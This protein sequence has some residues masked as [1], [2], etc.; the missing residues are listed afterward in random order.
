M[1]IF[2]ILWPKEFS[3]AKKALEEKRPIII[4][5][6]PMECG[7]DFAKSLIELDHARTIDYLKLSKV[8]L[9]NLKDNTIYLSNYNYSYSNDR[10][11]VCEITLGTID[12]RY[13]RKLFNHIMVLNKESVTTHL[14]ESTYQKSSGFASFFIKHMNAYIDKTI[15]QNSTYN[16]LNLAELSFLKLIN[17]F[18]VAVSTDIIT[19][20]I[21]SLNQKF[22][23]YGEDRIWSSSS[24]FE[25]VDLSVVDT[26][27]FISYLEKISSKYIQL[28]D[29]A[30]VLIAVLK[31]DE[32]LLQ[33]YFLKN[34]ELYL[35]NVKLNKY[36]G[37]VSY[38]EVET[39]VLIS[40]LKENI[41]SENIIKAKNELLK[42]FRKEIL[43]NEQRI[44]FFIATKQLEHRGKILSSITYPEKDSVVLAYN[45]SLSYR[46]LGNVEKA[47]EWLD[48]AISFVHD[49]KLKNEFLVA[50]GVNYIQGGMYHQSIKLFQEASHNYAIE[51]MTKLTSI[52]NF[53]IGI[54]FFHLGDLGKA[55]EHINKSK[56]YALENTYFM[57]S[58]KNFEIYML[59]LK[60]HY[61]D[62][63]EFV[64]E[65]FESD[66]LGISQ[67]IF[68]LDYKFS[69]YVKLNKL[70]DAY[71]VLR[72]LREE[73]YKNDLESL[74]SFYLKNKAMLSFIQH[75]T[76]TMNECLEQLINA[77]ELIPG[78][79][80]VDVFQWIIILSQ[81][82]KSKNYES[83]L[84]EYVTSLDD[85]LVRK[86]ELDYYVIMANEEIK[87]NH[88][89][90]AIGHL[91]EYITLCERFGFAV[92]RKQAEID[93]FDLMYREKLI[94]EIAECSSIFHKL[95]VKEMTALLFILYV[96]KKIS[97]RQFLD[98]FF[99]SYYMDV[100]DEVTVGIKLLANE[101]ILKEKMNSTY[102]F[103]EFPD[104]QR[105]PLLF[106]MKEIAKQVGYENLLITSINNQKKQLLSFFDY[107]DIC[108]E[109]CGL[110]LNDITGGI[111]WDSKN[112][113][114]KEGQNTYKVLSFLVENPYGVSKSKIIEYV[115]LEDYN[116]LV[117]DSYI[118]QAIHKIKNFFKK[119]LEDD[120]IVIENDLYILNPKL[121]I[122]KLTLR[123]KLL[124]ELNERQLWVLKYLKH[125]ESIIG[126]ELA[127][128]FKV[129]LRTVQR[130][131]SELV[132]S[133]LLFSSGK[134]KNCSYFQA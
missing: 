86:L 82:L 54:S 23:I 28:R 90:G 48:K 108:K 91:K 70:D 43:S 73:I 127:S 51:K 41:F 21:I 107:V 36:L 20:E 60:G 125:N 42:R 9:E 63:I 6:H 80:K 109:G 26:D 71:D 83:Y 88:A 12:K 57:N 81:Q 78:K 92:N 1:N 111:T 75:D 46:K 79:Y 93:L 115:W 128:N 31:S 19:S 89:L 62:V 114:L 65:L 101:I 105:E 103:F 37:N 134:G 98:L 94:D 119:Y 69:A 2:N 39:D 44:Q 56:E 33:K 16:D 85:N 126:N 13:F 110:L 53:N 66:N 124:S 24:Y 55:F 5:F 34:P 72:A 118:Y 99:D 29:S 32:V 77:L 67:K 35:Q 4:K 64:N 45:R 52:C 10:L 121:K 130:D 7:H 76:E 131:L 40:T 11:N 133:G 113:P 117:H 122:C 123:E 27:N 102:S 68:S 15:F 61:S 132:S 74:N 14:F 106:E 129:S 22:L 120:L 50:Q 100:N 58:L 47:I 25:I 38:R 3:L 30:Q 112:V 96:K 17:E 49:E 95:P 59:L 87:N 84:K 8:D 116:P 104:E 97:G 18:G